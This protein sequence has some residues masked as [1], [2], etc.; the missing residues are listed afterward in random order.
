MLPVFRSLGLQPGD[1]NLVV[2]LI[3]LAIAE[4]VS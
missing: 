3:C 2:R 1:K 4:A